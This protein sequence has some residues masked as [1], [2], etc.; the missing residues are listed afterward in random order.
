MQ[1]LF[2]LL[3]LF[4]T[5]AFSHNADS[6]LRLGRIQDPRAYIKAVVAI[7][8]DQFV[9]DLSRARSLVAKADSAL[10]KGKWPRE[11]VDLR[12]LQALV[13]QY[14]GQYEAAMAYQQQCLKL[15]TQLKDTLNM[16]RM[17]SGL[18][19]ISK[20]RDL[21]QGLKW[22]EEGKELLMS[23][24]DNGK[25]FDAENIKQSKGMGWENLYRRVGLLNGAL[26]VNSK[27]GRGTLIFAGIPLP[28]V[29][30]VA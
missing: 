26:E 3:C 18:G 19:Y 23:I 7:P 9:A 14:S 11:E 6:L 30:A 10:D 20:R 24:A 5:K 4:A 1:F 22:M 29:A 8:Y 13:S 25:G 17:L 12:R 16:A 15:Y 21:D 28:K 27:P 2:V